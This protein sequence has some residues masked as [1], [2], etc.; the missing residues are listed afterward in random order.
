MTWNLWLRE[1]WIGSLRILSYMFLNDSTH[2]HHMC[3]SL[4]IYSGD[5]P[6]TI[7]SWSDYMYFSVKI[8]DLAWTILLHFCCCYCPNSEFET[9]LISYGTSQIRI[10]L[11][12]LK[13]AYW[14][15]SV[16]VFLLYLSSLLLIF[17]Y[18]SFPSVSWHLLV[19]VHLLHIF[20]IG[21]YAYILTL[22]IIILVI[23][24][25]EF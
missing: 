7:F 6:F 8:S 21:I 1:L 14:E 9:W 25:T 3:T 4:S 11:F 19:L 23:P 20:C 10:D 22:I 18:T 13:C 15:N 24:Y 16:T 5:W 17:H 2:K 12:K